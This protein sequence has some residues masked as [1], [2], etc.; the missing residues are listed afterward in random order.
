MQEASDSDIE[1]V[2]PSAAAGEDGAAGLQSAGHLSGRTNSSMPAAFSAP[3]AA[4]HSDPDLADTGA[5]PAKGEVI[6]SICIEHF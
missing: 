1:E 4:A 2:T 3:S 6:P 5:S